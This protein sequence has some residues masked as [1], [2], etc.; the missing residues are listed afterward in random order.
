[1]QTENQKLLSW[2][3]KN[4][5]NYHCPVCQHQGIKATEQ[6]VQIPY[7][8]SN[9][10]GESFYTQYHQAVCSKCGFLMNFLSQFINDNVD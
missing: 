1:M 3:E 2:I 6:C 8:N 5:Q 10:K 9:N 7:P 4:G